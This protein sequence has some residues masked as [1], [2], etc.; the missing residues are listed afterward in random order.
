MLLFIPTLFEKRGDIDHIVGI[1]AVRP[2]WPGHYLLL[3]YMH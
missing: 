2:S 3:H 1:S